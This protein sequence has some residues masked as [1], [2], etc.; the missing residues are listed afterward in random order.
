[1]EKVNS[2]H[3][4]LKLIDIDYEQTVFEQ[5]VVEERLMEI[6]VIALIIA[7]KL[8]SQNLQQQLFLTPYGYLRFLQLVILSINLKY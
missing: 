3:L 1:M 7:F 8:I 2:V 5:I 6:H 4:L